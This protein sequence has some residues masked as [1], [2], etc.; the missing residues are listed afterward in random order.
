MGREAPTHA[1]ICSRCARNA[2]AAK[3]RRTCSPAEV[4]SDLLDLVA[5]PPGDYQED[6]QKRLRELRVLGWEITTRRQ[7]EDDRARTYYQLVHA[8]PWPEGNIRQAIR[9]REHQR[10]Y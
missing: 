8:E 5:G 3:R 6:W 4:R 9:R 1:R 7:R 2:T 10:G